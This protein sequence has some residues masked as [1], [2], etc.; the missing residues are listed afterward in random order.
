MMI[1]NFDI[2]DAAQCVF[3]LSFALKL[4]LFLAF[5]VFVLIVILLLKVTKKMTLA[6]SARV[7]LRI[8]TLLYVSVSTKVLDIFKCT[9]F[10][11]GESRLDAADYKVTCYTSTEH[12]TMIAFG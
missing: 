2:F 8:M 9:N 7:S 4:Y 1:V 6:A 5:P 11:K 3:Q 10:D 12:S